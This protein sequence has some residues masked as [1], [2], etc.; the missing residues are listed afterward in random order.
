LHENNIRVTTHPSVDT[1]FGGYEDT[2]ENVTNT[3]PEVHHHCSHEDCFSDNYE[4]IYNS[5]GSDTDSDSDSD[6]E[7]EI[8]CCDIRTNMHKHDPRKDM[9]IWDDFFT[10]HYANQHKS[11]PILTKYWTREVL[12]G[13]G[14]TML[15][16][17]LFVFSIKEKHRVSESTINTILFLLGLFCDVPKNYKTIL[18]HLD[19][20]GY[21]HYKFQ[22]CATCQR[23]VWPNS[24]QDETKCPICDSI[25]KEYINYV[26]YTSYLALQFAGNKVFCDQYTAHI[27]EV[28]AFFLSQRTDH[29]DW[30]SGTYGIRMMDMFD[31][32]STIFCSASFDGLSKSR[33]SKLDAWPMVIKMLSLPKWVRNDPRNLFMTSLITYASKPSAIDSALIP[34]LQEFR[35]LSTHTFEVFNRRTKQ[36]LTLRL[37]LVSANCDLAAW[38]QA[39]CKKNWKNKYVCFMGKCHAKSKNIGMKKNNQPKYHTVWNVQKKE[40]QT[41]I[42]MLSAAETALDSGKCCIGMKRVSPFAL[43]PYF[44]F[45]QASTIDMMHLFF[46]KGVFDVLYKGTLV[47]IGDKNAKTFIMASESLHIEATHDKKRSYR[48]LEHYKK[49][50][51]EEIMNFSLYYMMPILCSLVDFPDSLLTMWTNFNRLIT[52][53]CLWE[54]TPAE[55]DEIN[56]LCQ[57]IPDKIGSEFGETTPTLKVHLIRHIPECIEYLGPLRLHWCFPIENLLSYVRAISHGR[58]TI[59][60][61]MCLG[62]RIYSLVEAFE[63]FNNT[64]LIDPSTLLAGKTVARGTKCEDCLDAQVECAVFGKPITHTREII[65]WLQ[66]LFPKVQNFENINVYNRARIGGPTFHST[67]YQRP[68]HRQSTN[69]EIE[70]P[71]TKTKKSHHLIPQFSQI[72]QVT[73]FFVH[74]GIGYASVRIFKDIGI[75]ADG[76]YRM[77]NVEPEPEELIIALTQIRRK[78]VL[79]TVPSVKVPY[80]IL[81]DGPRVALPRT[82]FEPYKVLCCKET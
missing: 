69:V 60:A 31:F 76:K 25:K 24:V 10:K 28:S 12:A 63:G 7:T 14:I 52:L 42:Q 51:A 54:Y 36:P 39:F 55:F 48:S 78:G 73:G 30:Y 65:I 5:S 37:C 44:D 59:D 29:V 4:E 16:I 45:V 58:Q 67:L 47:K 82:C 1:E 74:K 50:K 38:Y 68:K 6:S 41:H 72:A 81:K 22:A 53:L 13:S 17:C 21:V 19:E 32:T 66:K 27:E 15:W 33:S 40:P 43:L 79:I 9:H 77:V 62:V 71:D 46:V 34:S 49:M 64:P 11:K 2:V 20:F 8:P 23:H 70:L 56:S 57:S 61:N 3:T 35:Y 75:H 26:P 80:A 18:R